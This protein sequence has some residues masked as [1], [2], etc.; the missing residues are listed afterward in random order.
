MSAPLPTLVFSDPLF[1]EHDPGRGHPESPARLQSV[2]S[3]L[4]DKPVAGVEMVKPRA[5]SEEEV[6]RVHT[7]ALRARLAALAGK[8]MVLDADTRVSP[9]SR[10]AA[11]LAAGAAVGATEAVWKGEARN[12]FILVRPPGHHAEPN[13][14]MGF[15]LLN[16]AAIAAEAARASGAPRVLVLDWDVHHG[17][18]TQAVFWERPDV[19]YQSVHQ[20]PFYPGTG[21]PTEVGA[22]PGAGFTVNCG[23][24]GGRNDAD[25]GAVFYDLL[26]PVAAAFLPDLVIV[27][28]GFDPHE[29]DPLGG[30]LCTERGF[31][32]MCTLVKQLADET[33]GGRL[34]LVLEGGYSLAGLPR[35]VHACLE[36][37]TGRS[38]EFPSGASREASQAIRAS[39]DALRPYWP[40]L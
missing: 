23:L 20:F 6:A 18:G 33:A 4:R 27:S 2:L 10:D 11:L 34:V 32:A 26:L 14:M 16:N 19:L 17:N 24:P 29:D 12:A 13:Q 1:L 3:L 7:P 36:V 15:C 38:E 35:S 22:G 30:M 5:A 39:R 37:L 28:A 21:A 8:Q 9:R 40:T 31:A 25:F